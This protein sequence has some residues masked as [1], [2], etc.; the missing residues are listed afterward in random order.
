VDYIIKVGGPGTI[1]QSFNCIKFEGII[2]VI[3]FLGS[4]KAK[5]QP[6]L[7]D[8]L[9]NICTVRGIYIGSKALIR[10]MIRVI[11]A[12]DIHPVLDKVFTLEQAREAYKYIVSRTDAISSILYI[13]RIPQ[14]AQKHF[15][16][17]TVKIH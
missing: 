3:S 5:G 7:L 16:K 15:G 4:V 14:W 1:R 10:D 17:L 2:S 8:T 13:N 12:N 9:S 11:K 6:T